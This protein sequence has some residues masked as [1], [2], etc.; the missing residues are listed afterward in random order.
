MGILQNLSSEFSNSRSRAFRPSNFTQKQSPASTSV[1]VLTLTRISK[2]VVTRHAP[3]TLELRNTPGKTQANHK[4]YTRVSYVAD[5]HS[6][7]LEP[8]ALIYTHSVRLQPTPLTL[9]R[10]RCTH[11]ELHRGCRHWYC[12]ISSCK[13]VQVFFFQC[14]PTAVVLHYKTAF[15][16]PQPFCWCMRALPQK[17]TRATMGDNEGN[18]P[19]FR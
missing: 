10:T 19:F 13:F 6:V 8:A 12:R 14:V 5:T 4:W 2:S 16:R 18:T 7:R 11:Y 15:F 1:V 9:V 17:G 3:V